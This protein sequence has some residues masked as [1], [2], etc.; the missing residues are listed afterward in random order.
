LERSIAI[1]QHDRHCIRA[2]TSEIECAVAVEI[3][4]DVGV[5][6][7]WILLSRERGDLSRN[8]AKRH[9]ARS[10]KNEQNTRRVRAFPFS[11]RDLLHTG[12]NEQSSQA[13]RQGGKGCESVTFSYN[14]RRDDAQN[15][16]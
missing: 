1:P 7:Q 10:A 3:S 11:H 6:K 15:A 5:A 8:F 4:G 13:I 2:S 16:D 12:C 14:A 9:C